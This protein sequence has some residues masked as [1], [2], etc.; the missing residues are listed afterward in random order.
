[1]IYQIYSGK[2]T[3]FIVQEN[4]KN[5][6]IYD[7]KDISILG[8]IDKCEPVYTVKNYVK[9]EYNVKDEKGDKF[10]VVNILTLEGISIV[11][12]R[13]G[14]FR[15]A[16][17][18][19]LIPI[20]SHVVNDNKCTYALNDSDVRTQEQ[21]Q[22]LFVRFQKISFGKYPSPVI[23][24]SYKQT[25]DIENVKIYGTDLKLFMTLYGKIKLFEDDEN[26]VI[27]NGDS[28]YVITREEIFEMKHVL[29]GIHV[30]EFKYVNNKLWWLI[31]AGDRILGM[32]GYYYTSDTMDAR[33]KKLIPGL[34]ETQTQ[35]KVNV[36]VKKI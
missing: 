11:V 31:C 24:I 21:I 25:G 30:D 19:N 12:Y 18:H 10:S 33:N 6:D 34:L 5:V 20:D 36:T 23:I 17:T 35:T 13:N 9:I 26:Y 14:I 15:M 8:N 16:E 7:E 22:T 28:I 32:N 3:T 1:M 29:I 2:I 4:G 27:E